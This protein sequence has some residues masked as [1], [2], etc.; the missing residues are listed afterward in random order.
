MAAMSAFG[1]SDDPALQEA[2]FDLMETK[3]RDPDLVYF[4]RGL[5]ANFNTRRAV[6]QY[7][8]D[9]YVTVSAT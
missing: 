2:T 6:V 1:N 4:L 8:A 3:A 7:Y 5:A 9:N